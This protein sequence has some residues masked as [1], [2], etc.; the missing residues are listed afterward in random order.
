MGGEVVIQGGHYEQEEEGKEN[1][2]FPNQP[3]SGGKSSNNMAE[4]KECKSNE[5][6]PDQNIASFLCHGALEVKWTAR[7]ISTSFYKANRIAKIANDEKNSSYGE[8]KCWC[9]SSLCKF[10]DD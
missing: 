1:S 4:T 10:V 6:D 7:A 9:I 2:E 3:A 8:V 5:D